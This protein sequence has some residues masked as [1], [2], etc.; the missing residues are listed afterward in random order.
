MVGA[1]KAPYRSPEPLYR[2]HREAHCRYAM[3]AQK[4]FHKQDISIAAHLARM[5]L[6]E[7]INKTIQ[8]R[9]Y[10]RIQT[11]VVECLKKVVN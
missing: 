5:D 8:Q 7:C 1:T 3:L 4:G 9:A 10:Q 2:M 11:S 6:V